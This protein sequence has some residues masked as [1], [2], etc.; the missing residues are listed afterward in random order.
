MAL[1]PDAFRETARKGP[2][3]TVCVIE[4]LLSPEDR[5]ILEG[6]FADPRV[7]SG[8]IAK[9]LSD[10]GHDVRTH[11]VQRHRRGGCLR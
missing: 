4:Q 7:T 9:V 8:A 3:C 11:T 1:S 2:R 10:N 6:A 5:K